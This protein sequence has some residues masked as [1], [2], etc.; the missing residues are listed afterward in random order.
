MDDLE[1][2]QMPRCGASHVMSIK[3]IVRN[4]RNR[5]GIH[6][7]YPMGSVQDRA[8]DSFIQGFG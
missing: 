7:A 6:E 3:L 4:E 8:R 2:V 5:T 1:L